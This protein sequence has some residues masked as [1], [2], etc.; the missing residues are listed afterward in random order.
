MARKTFPGTLMRR[1]GTY[2]WRWQI[3]GKRV[4]RTFKTRDRAEAIRQLRAAIPE[5]EA[6]A[7]RARRGI[8]PGLTMKDLL[9]EFETYYLP[10][11]GKGTQNAYR[12]STAVFR[13]Y[14]VELRGD[15]TIASVAPSDVAAFIEWRRTSRVKGDE[16]LSQRTLRKDFAVLHTLFA[17]A[18]ESREYRKDNPVAKKL[19]PKRGQARQAVIISEAEEAKLLQACAEHAMLSTFVLLCLET[20]LRPNSEALWLRWEDI[21]FREGTLKV[22]SGRDGHTTKTYRSRT[23]YLSDR[24]TAGLR[25]HFAAFRLSGSPWVF[26]HE[27]TRRHHKAGTRIADLLH[28]FKN[29][30]EKVGLPTDVRP[31]DLRH[32]RITRW[33]G[34][35]HNLAIVQKAAG[36]S[37]INT[38]MLYV[39]LANESLKTLVAAAKDAPKL[40][41]LSAS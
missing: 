25:D 11:T 31:Y 7:E 4:H 23:L 13:R 2:R 26:H 20:G 10:G 14:F 36:H 5:V 21:D 39:H 15:P 19:R 17:W 40:E 9:D 29:A 18:V 3:D 35:G 34:A 30:A 24:L 33:V 1:G 6:E 12:D 41:A 28:S 38:T 27:T 32:T 22:V 16:P 37:S 8:R